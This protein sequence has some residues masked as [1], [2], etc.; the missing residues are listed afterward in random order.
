MSISL[1][2][3]SLT[4]FFQMEIENSTINTDECVASFTPSMTFASTFLS[5][6]VPAVIIIAANIGKIS[7]KFEDIFHY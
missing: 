1:A 5:F 4:P 2:A 3:I 6:V 7:K